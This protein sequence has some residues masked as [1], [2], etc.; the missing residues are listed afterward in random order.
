MALVMGVVRSVAALYAWV[1]FSASAGRPGLAGGGL[2]GGAGLHIAHVVG[3]GGQRP[4][5]DGRG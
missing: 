1:F 2:I 4:E 5:R 3:P